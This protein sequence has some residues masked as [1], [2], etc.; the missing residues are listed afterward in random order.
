MESKKE[1]II[2]KLTGKNGK[3]VKAHIIPK[4]FF[5][6]DGKG[7]Y[8][9][10]PKD[11]NDTTTTHKRSLIGVYDQKILIDEG[12]R[13]FANVD[14]Y[15]AKFLLNKKNNNVGKIGEFILLGGQPFCLK[16][17]AKDYDEAT[18]RLFFISVLWRAGVSQ[19]PF[20]ENV[21]LGVE[22]EEKLR[23]L[24][25]NQDPGDPDDYSVTIYKYI[26]TPESGWPIF[27]PYMHRS[28]GSRYYRF[29]FNRIHVDI[30]ACAKKQPQ[31]FN[32]KS[33]HPD[34]DLLMW[35]DGYLK[36]SDFYHKYVIAVS[37]RLSCSSKNNL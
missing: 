37:N 15:A 20:Y 35:L 19:N 24:I 18:L 30:K 6:N 27:K 3:P 22:H 31:L 12:E 4:A 5:I 10:S 34:S 36:E 11:W 29:F 16:I 14:D 17:G 2:C 9:F 23:G 1:N 33:M 32:E 8:I 26:D 7:G 21:D 13:Y 25:L 28:N